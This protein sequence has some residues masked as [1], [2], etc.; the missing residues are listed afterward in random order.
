MAYS[1][2]DEDKVEREFAEK[3]PYGVSRVQ[4]VGA[5]A[6]ETEDGKSWID[7]EITTA[8]GIEDTA[9]V[10]FTGK[11]APY[12][13]NTLR[14]IAVHSGKDDAAKEELRQGI[15]NMQDSDELADFLNE[16]VAGGE[17]WFT[18]YLDPQRTWT[19]NDGNVRQSVNKNVY[20][21]EPKLKPELMPK[22]VPLG[23]EQ[24]TDGNVD[25]LFPG[26]DKADGAAPTVPVKF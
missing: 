24:I 9:R 26:D 13:F 2:N 16:K 23:G 5:T 3:L 7:L 12:S 10:W 8:D 14:Q 17:L 6:G 11:A 1:F 4:L 20:G 15:E 22:D 19:D 18:K 25:K 21:Y